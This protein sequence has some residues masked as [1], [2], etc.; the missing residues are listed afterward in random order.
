MTKL[1][2]LNGKSYKAAPFDVNLVC[3]FEETGIA[4]EDIITNLERVSDHCSNIGVC[5]VQISRGGFEAH[6]YIDDDVKK[7]QWFYDEVKRYSEMY[8]LKT[9]EA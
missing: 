9:K 4:L 2:I 5:M 3:D 1:L 8:T 6:E 7:S